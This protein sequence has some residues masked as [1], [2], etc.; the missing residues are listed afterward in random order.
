[1]EGNE[2]TEVCHRG[3]MIARPD[4][5]CKDEANTI[6][7]VKSSKSSNASA[8]AASVSKQDSVSKNRNARSACWQ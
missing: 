8:N 3:D 7:D 1:M 4:D 2:R 5:L 6:T